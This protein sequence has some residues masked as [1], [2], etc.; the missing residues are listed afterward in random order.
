[1][2]V[3]GPGPPAHGGIA[4]VLDAITRSPISERFIFERFATNRQRSGDRSLV[5]RGLNVLLAR[6]F[7]FDGAWNLDALDV[8]ASF[9]SM[10]ASRPALVDLHCSHGWDFWVSVRMAA[11]ARRARAAS[12]LHLH[13]NFDVVWPQW[14]HTRRA[15]FRRALLIPDRVIVLSESW[16]AWIAPHCDPG[17][18]EVV[19]NGVDTARFAPRT[20]SHVGEQLRVLFVGTRDASIKGG[21]DVIAVAGEIAR[22]VPE[23][24]FVFVGED[25]ENL[26][27]QYVQGR[28]LARHLEFLGRQ[29]PAAMPALYANSDVLL[30]PSHREALPVALLEGM[31]SG[32]PV[33]AS[34]LHSIREVLAP[35]EGNATIDP[36]D[37]AELADAVINLLRD[38]ARRRR[39]ALSNRA[40]IESAY[41]MQRF[42]ERLQAAFD[43]T[44][45]S[46]ARSL[47][48][49]IGL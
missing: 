9:R 18:V 22:V 6:G 29:P 24:R 26:E 34:G 3:C 1:V 4:A 48:R 32:L 2:L 16:R 13:G 7:G 5:G 23:V 28:P 39:A 37:R 10:L 19:P 47:G 27:S 21:H 8:V 43:A 38:P 49:E 40:R 17:R 31:A 45:R 36:G 35:T 12:L 30:L 25:T 20:T 44:I 14:S 42:A 33:V 46:H 15:A 11:A 41:G